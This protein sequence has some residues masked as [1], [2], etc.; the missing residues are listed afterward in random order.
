MF[1]G[2]AN[3]VFLNIVLNFVVN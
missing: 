3:L 2:P 1:A